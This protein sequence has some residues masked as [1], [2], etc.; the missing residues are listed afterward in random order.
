[1]RSDLDAREVRWEARAGKRD[2]VSGFARFETADDPGAH[3]A[4][5]AERAAVRR[6][7]ASCHTPVGVYAGGGGMRGF[8][9]LPDGSEWLIDA[10]PDAEALAA[11]MLSAGAAELLARAESAA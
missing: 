1:M 5:A 6:L 4:L 3:A 11:R 8:A 7:G 10:A 2:A 9:G